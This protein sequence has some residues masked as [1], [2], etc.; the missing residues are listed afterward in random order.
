MDGRMGGQVNA[1]RLKVSTEDERD[2]TGIQAVYRGP[3]L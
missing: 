3:N 2:R 1:A